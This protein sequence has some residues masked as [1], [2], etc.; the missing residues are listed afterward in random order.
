MNNYTVMAKTED[1]IRQAHFGNEKAAYNYFNDLLEN[2]PFEWVELVDH[3]NAEV[4]E[5]I[6]AGELFA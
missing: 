5:Y 2:M 3:T 6:E 4:I 1:G